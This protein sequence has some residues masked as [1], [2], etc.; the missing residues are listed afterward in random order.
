MESRLMEVNPDGTRQVRIYVKDS[1]IGI[2]QEDIPKLFNPFERI[3]AEKTKMEGTG[4][5]LSVVKKLTDAMGGYIGVESV[6]GEGSTFWIEFPLSEKHAEPKEILDML[7]GL[8]SGLSNRTGTILYIE[9]NVSNIELVGEILSSQRS[10]ISMISNANGLKALP[11]AIEYNPDM[12]L[13]DLNLPDI[14]GSEVLGLLKSN[15]KTRAIPVIVISADAMPQQI[16]KFHAAGARNYLTK[17]LDLSILLKII[18]EYI[19]G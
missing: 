3:G 6:V 8:E 9:D 7:D 19:V 5:G 15:E 17:P 4:L 12:I 2:S 1:G 18:D 13:L 10:N 11:M 16:E 14:H